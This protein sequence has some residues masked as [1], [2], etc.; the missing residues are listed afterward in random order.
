[1]KKKRWSGLISLLIVSLNVFGQHNGVNIDE[2]ALVEY[3]DSITPVRIEIL[4]IKNSV[5]RINDSPQLIKNYEKLISERYFL[6]DSDRQRLDYNLLNA[7]VGDTIYESDCYCP[8]YLI[9]TYYKDEY[10]GFIGIDTKCKSLKNYETRYK[11]LEFSSMLYTNI[12]YL[13]KEYEF[14]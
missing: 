9:K 2:S 14:E 8:D 13:I 3:S 4:K 5:I 11:D 12:I 7:I 10:S 6:T 1:M